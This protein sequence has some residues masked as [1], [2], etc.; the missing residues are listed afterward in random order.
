MSDPGPQ[1]FNDQI[2]AEFR[3]NEGKVAAFGDA[4]MV[5][6]HSKGAKSGLARET[7]LVAQVDGDRLLIFASAAGSTSHPAW[8]HNLMADPAVTVE[9]GTDSFAARA[10]ELEG[11]ERDERFQAQAE[12][13]PQFAEYTESAGDRIIPV[14]AL[15]RV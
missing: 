15:E 4:P 14:I 10:V 3:E 1:D 13:M 12:V 6:V 9:Y 5:I 2:M 7:P 8:Y 11:A